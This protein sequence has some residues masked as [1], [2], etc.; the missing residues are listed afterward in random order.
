VYNLI[1]G[2]S[3]FSNIL[4]DP[5]TK[6]L[7]LIDPRG[8]F[9]NTHIYGLKCYDYG[10][11]GYA[12]SGYDLFNNQDNQFFLD[13]ENGSLNLTV[14][15][16]FDQLLDHLSMLTNTPQRILMALICINWIGLAEYFINYPLKSMGS[17]LYAHYFYEKY[18]T[19]NIEKYI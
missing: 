18:I 6:T 19:K 1:H 3:Q 5:A 8:Y 15:N 11:I 17:I 14:P 4:Y 16:N 13:I 12:L 10:K 7:N 2:D 9:G